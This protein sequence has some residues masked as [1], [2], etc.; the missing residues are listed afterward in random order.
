MLDW[1]L[2][3]VF[4]YECLTGRPPFWDTNKEQ[5]LNNIKSGRYKH[6]STDFSK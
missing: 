3:G 5:L 6:L 1:Y 4:V 2:L